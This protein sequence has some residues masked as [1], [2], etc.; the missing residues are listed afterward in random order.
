M[1]SA[2][3][4]SGKP[5]LLKEAFGAESQPDEADEKYINEFFNPSGTNAASPE[6]C[7]KQLTDMADS[8]SLV[9]LLSSGG[10]GMLLT[11][12][13]EVKQPNHK[14]KGK[15]V[16]VADELYEGHISSVVH[17]KP[18][19]FQ[20]VEVTV[21][22][23]DDIQK[24]FENDP[25][26]VR[27]E[28][29]QGTRSSLK[30]KV[31]KT[32]RI[33]HDHVGKFFQFFSE[34]GITPRAF[35]TKAYP[36][37]SDE[38][39]VEC[40]HVIQYFQALA[41]K[42]KAGGDKSTVE[43]DD[44]PQALQSDKWILKLMYERLYQLIPEM[45]SNG[46]NA[47]LNTCATAI[48]SLAH[49]TEEQAAANADRARAAQAAKEEEKRAKKAMKAKLGDLTTQKLLRM[50]RL[51]RESEIP[52]E[53]VLGML[54]KEEGQWKPE[55]CRKI[56]QSLVDMKANTLRWKYHIPKVTLAMAKMLLDGEWY[57]SNRDDLGG[58]LFSN[59]LLYGKTPEQFTNQQISD[60][61]QVDDHGSNTTVQ[62]VAKLLKMKTYLPGNREIVDNVKRN[63]LIASVVLP[64]DHDYIRFLDR[65]CI[66]L[67][68]HSDVITGIVLD[69]HHAKYNDAKG[70]LVLEKLSIKLN[71]YW[72]SLDYGDVC[73][74]PPRP[75]DLFQQIADGE[76]WIPALSPAYV[77]K[78]GLE[79][80]RGDAV[81]HTLESSGSGYGARV[82]TS[83]G[84]EK[85]P[86]S[87]TPSPPTVPSEKESGKDTRISNPQYLE[88]TFSQF[89]DRKKKNG[90]QIPIGEWK[91]I[92][93][94]NPPPKSKHFDGTMCVT[95]HGKGHCNVTC[96]KKAD[97]K[98][99][100]AS[101]YKPFL[102][103][104]ET[105]WPKCEL[106]E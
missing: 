70:I 99:Y 82:V 90:K 56:F 15:V 87:F 26:M 71:R 59:F 14:H 37:F 20:V 48:G 35:W 5:C 39:K 88:G 84:K 79:S 80:F 22:E 91:H 89:R 50:M 7:L 49:A 45:R 67:M 95:W 9:V 66:E 28:P 46:T 4:A 63:L 17:V 100:T 21:A 1:A 106:A 42:D 31:R 13:K 51:E 3:L 29:P 75:E 81:S 30:V 33:P 93:A 73:A 8:W 53:T 32:I 76:H 98:P 52:E 12:A 94:A 34:G 16:A 25:G 97:H 103:W 92:A 44:L 83:A 65:L 47:S 57:K 96:G 104:C 55:S 74:R 61:R 102:E 77:A 68:N 43:V 23:A 27:M 60:S 69:G 72:Q 19:V 101:E 54:L 6:I 105:Y 18:D 86:G 58:G 24:A 41:T 40:K 36:Q 78:L 11:H 64:E 2:L 62:E 10:E 85:A 38:E